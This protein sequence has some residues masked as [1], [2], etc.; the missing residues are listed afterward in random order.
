MAKA[1]F[2][3]PEDFLWGTTT[4]AHQAEGGN[5]N[6]DWWR[7]EQK[8][9]HIKDGSSSRVAANWWEDAR[10]DLDRMAEMGQNAHRLSI[11]WSR[12]EPREGQ[13][14]DDAIDRYREL[15]TGLRDRGITPMVTL[16]H[17][18]NPQWF[19]DQG[20]WENKKLALSR[21]PRYVEKTV[22][23]LGAL[24][25]LWCTFNEP[26]NYVLMGWLW[27]RWPPGRSDFGRAMEVMRTLLQGHGAAYHLIHELQPEARVGLSSHFAVFDPANPQ[28]WLDRK[29]AAWQDMMFN[30][31][32]LMALGQGR[33]P[34]RTR[35]LFIRGVKG[36]F[37]W[38]G[39]NYY[40]RRRVAFDSR[41]SNALFGRLVVPEGSDAPVEGMG[42]TY[43]KGILRLAR[44]L[45]AL[46]K[47]IYVTENGVHDLTD[48]RRPRFLLTHLLE[49]WH[50]VQFNL[51]VKGY[52]H[53]TLLD[54]FEWDAGYSLRFG[55][56]KLDSNSGQRTMR[57]SGEL[58]TDICRAN[59]IDDE[60]M[61]RYDP[62]LA[63][64]VFQG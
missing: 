2:Y 9:G 22:G 29:A 6:N 30:Q 24:T 36:T 17:F 7:W 48:E 25:D 27:G 23:A 14:D 49:L 46:G 50:A 21:F 51:L 26:N 43:A 10:A 33:L 56:V 54:G 11:E 1:T 62:E 18:S 28:S 45:A 3:F 58:Y 39:M 47:P 42:E 59:A 38:I 32:T 44:R 52:F 31:A 40:Y 34:L 35:R 61:A 55:L 13:W 57:R 60:I 53:Y 41:R 63:D 8:E 64:H 5:T 4:A 20:G 16:H 15:L 37:D 12:I 19:V